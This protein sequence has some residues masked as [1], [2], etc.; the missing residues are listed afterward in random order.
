[1]FNI[2]TTR[3]DRTCQGFNRR[4]FLRIGGLG[5]LGGLTLPMLL[6][7]KAHAA[8]AGHIVKDKSV[9]FL[10]LSGG[11]SH[12][13]FFDPKMD[14]PA[15][16]RSITGEVET[17]L[18]GITFAGSFS[19]IASKPFNCSRATL[20]RPRK[21]GSASFVTA[22]VTQIYETGCAIY[23]YFAYYYKGVAKPK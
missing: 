18:P 10:F 6:E 20:R 17:R 13:E 23:F 9:V 5:M 15:E 1:M 22:R 21:M 12:I 11:P 3:N 8:A 19:T 2:A 4:D 16:I 14:A 7:A